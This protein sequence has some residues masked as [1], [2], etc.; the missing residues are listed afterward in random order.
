MAGLEV[1]RRQEARADGREGR[2]GEHERGVVARAGDESA[3]E[4]GADDGGDEEGDVAD[5]GLVGAHALDGLEPDGQVVDCDE[6]GG[7]QAEGEDARG[8]D[9][10][11]P[12]QARVDGGGFRAAEL[13]DH[14]GDEAEAEDD[15]E[16]DD[17]PARPGVGGAAPLQR[18]EEADDPREEEG[19]AEDV[20]LPEALPPGEGAVRRV[21]ASVGDGLEEEDYDGKRDAAD[22][23]V[24]VEAPAPCHLCGE[25]A[26]YR[27]YDSSIS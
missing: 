6:E 24:D 16:G 2:A 3:G 1:K 26:A 23:Q 27:L 8:A 21:L 9:A 5:A 14:E 12:D 4:D 11:F 10:A 25:S 22:G 18:H 17:A 20:E 15:E 19:R 7:T 13:D